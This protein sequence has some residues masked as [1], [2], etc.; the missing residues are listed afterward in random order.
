VKEMW[1]GNKAAPAY[2]ANRREVLRRAN[3]ACERCGRATKLV[4]HHRH[5]VQWRKTPKNADHRPEAMEALCQSCHDKEHRAE[6]IYRLKQIP[7]KAEAA[8]EG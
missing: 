7:K 4:V 8:S 5:R 6:M 2:E 3:G 1:Q